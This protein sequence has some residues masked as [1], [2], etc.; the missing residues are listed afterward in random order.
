MY[1]G[2]SVLVSNLLSFMGSGFF[3]R[4]HSRVTHKMYI[5]DYPFSPLC[6]FFPPNVCRH[7][8]QSMG[9]LGPHEHVVKVLGEA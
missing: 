2:K 5:F 4:L 1:G 9:I 7:I 6:P 8:D 3:C